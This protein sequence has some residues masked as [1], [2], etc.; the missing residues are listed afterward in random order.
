[1]HISL[2][3]I[4]GTREEQLC[5]LSAVLLWGVV[6]WLFTVRAARKTNNNITANDNNLEAPLLEEDEPK[7]AIRSRVR[8]AS[9]QAAYYVLAIYYAVCFLVYSVR[10]LRSRGEQ[11]ARL[12]RAGADLLRSVA[13][14]VAAKAD[15]QECRSSPAKPSLAAA[16]F[17]ACSALAA[18]RETR[19]SAAKFHLSAPSLWAL[20]AHA[21]LLV[22][23]LTGD[24]ATPRERAPSPEEN[25][26]EL[27]Q[28][29]GF[30][31]LRGLFDR[32][33]V[34][35]D[36]NLAVEDLP[37]Q[38]EGD[39]VDTTWPRLQELLEKHP[40]ARGGDPGRSRTLALFGVLCR[41]C[42][43]QFV[44]AGICRLF[45]IVT[46]YAQPLGLYIILRR[47]GRD[48]AF[49]WTA[50]GLLFGGPLLNATADALQMF[51]QRRVATRCR[52]AIM[53]LIYDKARRVDMAA[54]SLPPAAA[55]RGRP[56][57]KESGGGGRVGEVV[58][59]MSADVQNA[60]TAIAYFH[61][62]W[63]PVIQ[64]V[65]TLCALFWLVHV[66][67]VGALIVI[68]LNTVLN[69][70]IFGRLAAASKEFLS[71]RNFR[72]ELVTEMLQ[73]SR[74]IKMLGYESGIFDAIK[75]RREKELGKLAKIL[76]LQVAVATLINATP[77]IMGVAT[78]VAM[79]WLLGK[80]IDA[81]TG[82][83]TLTL[84]EN[85]R[86]VLMQAPSAATFI[87]T[88]Y[89]SLQRVESF[90][91]APDV[92]DKPS[93]DGVKRGEVRVEDAAFRW[94]GTADAAAA[95]EENPLITE[96]DP[97]E[98]GL[99]LR[100]VDLRMAPGTLTL[101]VGVTGGGKS[102]LLAALLGEIRRVKG[103]VRVG[104]S[105]AYCPQ[106]AWCQNASLKENIC[107]GDAGKDDARYGACIEACALGPDI[108]SFPGGDGTEVGERG[109][110]LS[111][112][113]QARVA[114]AR[115][116]YADADVYLLDDPLSAVDAHVGEHLFESAICGLV[117]RGKTVVLATHQVSL[118]LPRADQVVIL[119]TDGSVAFAGSPDEA[120]AD[121]AAATLL[122]D[123]ADPE[124]SKTAEAPKAVA[125]SA[126]IGPQGNAN[127]RLVEEEKRQKGAPLLSNFKL[128]LSAAGVAFLIGSSLFAL[129]QPTKY[130]QANSL[131]NWISAMEAGRKPL[132]GNGLTLYL[133][134]TAVFCVQTAIAISFQNLGALRA[135][136]TIHE[137]LSWAVL[138][139]PV[140]WFDASPVGR[141][142]NRFA[143][144]IQAVDRSVAMT[145]MFLIRS[146][147]AP[148]VSLFAIG[149]QVP[150]LLPCFIP[151]L[152]VA[153]NVARNYLLLAR[154]LKRIDST[155][156][157]PV[158][159]LFNE[160]LN[161]L[162]TLRSFDGAFGRF[163]QRFAGLV[164][165]TNSAELHLAALSYW[166]SVR[167]N[168]L[169]STVA[170]S[171]ALALYAQS[172]ANEDKLSPPEAGLVLTYAVSFTAAIIGLMR[173]YTELELSMNAVERIAVLFCVL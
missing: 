141:V 58:G 82:F 101:V 77:P 156:K 12:Y 29:V 64:L 142:Q 162:Q 75:G 107:F 139:N 19:V 105:T 36:E 15:A 147:V 126:P 116:L 173:T 57:K 47:F 167:L 53:V 30:T 80:P 48:D 140:A 70:G 125:K 79:S 24:K 55:G 115:A 171:T 131:T 41:L 84:L 146:L 152:A 145:T 60:L 5:I 92:D 86:F 112:G 67:A 100:G 106:Q 44:A 56:Q 9:R 169:G 108:S 17:V 45:Y 164:D 49:G 117:A 23:A 25:A 62:V 87:I 91:D 38:V 27:H 90:L 72:L 144:D 135:S 54:A 46:G 43:P 93:G 163:A 74:I 99:T 78:F 103:R 159:A 3:S 102:S 76:R 124:S 10:L 8:L 114:L 11:R 161:G 33:A 128:Y 109:V 157:S 81:A 39:L 166:L 123:L 34:L 1:M 143:T 14:L 83:T 96:S 170:G 172:L 121:A 149:R 151:V 50:V 150:W 110:T 63:G 158:Y 154:D 148:C 16:A 88:G 136:R 98:R 51:L 132:S 122:E 4:G 71:A 134:W 153:F 28:I 130:V 118:A 137:K 66:A 61:W 94:G 85:L 35:K 2:S 59:L 97:N 18:L 31:W 20:C 95:T 111:G 73:G 42:W 37:Q 133:V 165:R 13:W 21:I 32:K 7:H 155:T 120:A 127:S 113:Q 160:S 89:V 129:Q 138:R 6:A 26:I 68:A 119:T 52:G 22:V 104:G 40:E 65:I 168:A 69:K